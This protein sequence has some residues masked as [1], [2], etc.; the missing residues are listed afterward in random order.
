MTSKPSQVTSIADVIGH[1][2][3]I[4]D[5]RAYGWAFAPTYP[6]KRLAIEIVVDDE[7][8]AYG[9]AE[10]FREDLQSASIGDGHYL[11]DLQLSHE[12]FD[13][14]VHSLTAREAETGIVL[15]G[16]PLDFNTERR[17]P[18]Y[19]QISRARG[20]ALLAEL[21]SQPLYSQFSTKRGN[22]ADAYR[23]ASRLQETGQLFDARSA[24]VT[25]NNALGENSLGYCKLGE[26]LM[27]EGSPAEALEAFRTSAGNDLRFHWAHL[28]IANSQYALG[29]YEEAEEALKVAIALQPQ[30]A[31]LQERLHHIQD[32]AL[33]QRVKAML[34]QYKRGEAIDLLKSILLRRPES[35]EALALLGDL[36]CERDETDL[37]GMAK[38]YEFRKARLILDALLDDVESRLNEAAAQ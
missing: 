21:L 32:Q 31:S 36:L 1:F 9:R 14:Q 3:Y 34:S 23:F 2:D 6:Q 4:L 15:H 24:W 37:P 26:C 33:P 30:D 8:V 35:N 17:E 11:F 13:G 12:L 19:P 10:Q 16:G 20:L 28:G 25:I 27:L 18:D 7:V 5:G 38:L 29:Q 22:F